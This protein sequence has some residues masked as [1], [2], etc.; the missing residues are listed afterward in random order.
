MRT[1]Y[2]HKESNFT[3]ESSTPIVTKFVGPLLLHANPVHALHAAP[4]QYV[5]SVFVSNLNA[6]NITSGVLQEGTI[7]SFLGDFENNPGET[8]FSLKTSAIPEA[9]YT[10]VIVNSKGLVVGA[11]D[12]EV[13]DLPVLNW[14]KVTKDLPSSLAGYGIADGISLEGDTLP[15][16]L[17]YQ[18][19]Q[20]EPNNPATRET[21]YSLAGSLLEP[22]EPVGALVGRTSS[23]S[24]SGFLRANGS[25]LD[26]TAYPDLYSAIGDDHT[27]YKIP[28][29]GGRPWEQQYETNIANG[30]PGIWGDTNNDLPYE[31]HWP[32]VV[33]TKNRVYIVASGVTHIANF[34]MKTAVI[35]SD[36]TLGNWE[37]VTNINTLGVTHSQTLVFGNKVYVFGG[38]RNGQPRNEI[39]V[40]NI[41]PDGTISSFQNSGKVLPYSVQ[42]F[43]V[44]AIGSKLHLIGVDGFLVYEASIRSDGTFTDWTQKQN[45]LNHINYQGSLVVTDTKVFIFNLSEVHESTFNP[46]GSLGTWSI[47]SSNLPTGFTPLKPL[48]TNDKIFL[49]GNTTDQQGNITTSMVVSNT[50]GIDF[51][52][53]T[54]HTG[55][56][57]YSMEFFLVKN[58]YYSLVGGSDCKTHSTPMTGSGSDFSP[59]YSHDEYPTQ[60][61]LPDLQDQEA[62]GKYYFIRY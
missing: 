32:A 41:N 17:T 57:A 54:T 39:Y 58:R 3:G 43:K 7:P 22:G 52:S 4:K 2:F 59:I 61:A 16:T 55:P 40:S 19:P 46:D 21:V 1:S 13:G 23:A 26:K 9:T 44:V 18:G 34:P 5:D 27:P 12:L 56:P 30:N 45:L 35:N 38:M 62:Q 6:S 51:G 36:G 42:N 28:K 60:F 25:L 49:F 48:V 31:L 53:W 37:D 50:N 10:K 29:G 24:L 33:V 15:G 8:S 47:N 14:T 20:S 11:S